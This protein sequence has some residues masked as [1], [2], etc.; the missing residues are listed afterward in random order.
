MLATTLLKNVSA[1][2]WRVVRAVFCRRPVLLPPAQRDA[3]LLVC[4]ECPFFDSPAGRCDLCGCFVELKAPL[5][6][7]KCPDNRWPDI[8]GHDA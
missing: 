5:R 6:T 7:E 2:L 3:R 1:A 4:E 8:S